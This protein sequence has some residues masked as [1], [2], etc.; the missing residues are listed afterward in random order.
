MG[1]Q[2]VKE[3]KLVNIEVEGHRVGWYGIW[4]PKPNP[5]V[6]MAEFFEAEDETRFCCQDPLN[7]YVMDLL[8]RLAM[9]MADAR[10]EDS[11]LCEI[12]T[13]LHAMIDFEMTRITE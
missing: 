1:A 9:L 12:K 10:K 11:G 8:K 3:F 13:Y 6:E 7:T 4:A 2:A 5:K